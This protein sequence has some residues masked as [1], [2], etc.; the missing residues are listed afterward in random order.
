MSTSE[1]FAAAEVLLDLDAGSKRALLKVLAAKA[2][3][4]LG[5]PEAE[6]LTALEDREAL[7]STAVGRGVALPHARLAG[8]GPP[9]MILARLRRAI[10]YE[11]R[12]EEPVDLIILVLWPEAQADGFLPALAETCRAFREP[13]ALRRLRAA[14]TP[15]EFIETLQRL[16]PDA[17]EQP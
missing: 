5:R 12:D 8:D 9:L 3:E 1:H 15:D 16:G 11:A 14:A 6:I 2:A 10:D 4:R 7:G 17:G 13:K